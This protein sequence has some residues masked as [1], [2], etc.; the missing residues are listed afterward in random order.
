FLASASELVTPAPNAATP[1]KNVRRDTFARE[2]GSTSFS[3][4]CNYVEMVRR[5]K[6]LRPGECWPSGGRRRRMREVE[7]G[8]RRAQ[9]A[10]QSIL[11]KLA[12]QL[13]SQVLPPS[14]EKACSQWAA[15]AVMPDQM[16]RTLMGLPRK[17]SA[18]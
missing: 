10:V 1:S 13:V 3:R 16:K 7:S 17:L 2:I 5:S 15:V 9:L 8:L 6:R 11:L 4:Y 14:P 12:V 18:E